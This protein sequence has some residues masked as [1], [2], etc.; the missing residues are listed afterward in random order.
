M[1]CAGTL[2]SDIT[3][4]LPLYI[5]IHL[6]LNII[7]NDVYIS[8]RNISPQCIN[9]FISDLEKCDWDFV[10]TQ[11]TKYGFLRCIW[12]NYVAKVNKYVYCATS[13]ET[14]NFL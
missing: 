6:N 11:E 10:T 8:K 3:Y 4:H 7:E 13:H 12:L 5:N 1:M 14:Y 9:N 2:C